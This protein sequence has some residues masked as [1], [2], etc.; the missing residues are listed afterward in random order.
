MGLELRRAMAALLGFAALPG[1]ALFALTVGVA[2]PPLAGAAVAQETCVATKTMRGG[3][4]N[5]RPGAAIVENLGTG[6]R[7]TGAAREAGTCRALPNVRL[8]IWTATERGGEREPS[9]VGSVLT[10]DD[11]TFV[12]ETSPVVPNF[13]Q[14]HIHVAF[15]DPGFETV[16]LR[17]VLDRTGQPTIEVNLNL[18]PTA[19]RAPG[20]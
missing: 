12:L 5:Y 6:F 13:G 20:S 8:Q 15:D 19:D 14:P 3:A 4:N 11:G 16:F 17:P 18:A 2:S 1:I 10:G 9:N 7:I